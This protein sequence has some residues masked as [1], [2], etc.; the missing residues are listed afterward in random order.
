MKQTQRVFSLFMFNKMFNVL[1][2]F[3]IATIVDNM[4]LNFEDFHM[5]TG[6]IRN[7]IRIH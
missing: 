2:V 7:E 3:T 1:I 6:I 4:Y 5:C